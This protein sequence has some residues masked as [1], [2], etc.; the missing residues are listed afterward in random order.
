M[1]VVVSKSVGYCDEEHWVNSRL[2]VKHWKKVKNRHGL[3]CLFR[4]NL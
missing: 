1:S 4:K 3:C 2:R